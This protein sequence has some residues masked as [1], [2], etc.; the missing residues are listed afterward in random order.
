MSWYEDFDRVVGER[1]PGLEVRREEPMGEHTTFRIGGAARRMALPGDAEEAA[2]LLAL[3][4]EGGWPVLAVG[5]GSNLLV[6]DEGI[7]RLVVL[8][9]RMD[10]VT[11]DG[12]SGAVKTEAGIRLSRLAVAAMEAG[13]GGLA[14]AHGIPGTLG[15]AVMMNAGAYGGEM[16]QVIRRVTAWFPVRGVQTLE[17]EELGFGYR[18]SCF[19]G[20]DGVVLSAELGLQPGCS[21]AEIR[22]EMEALIARRRASQPLELPSA[23]ST[24]K[25]PAGYYAGT[26]IDQCGLKGLRVGGAQVSEKHAGFIVNR[27]GATCADVT[28]LITEVQRRVK[29][30][31]GVTLEPEVRIIR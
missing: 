13:L 1:M 8:T 21:P 14:F 16:A 17:G 26:L 27:G 4:E 3:A 15:G 2:K 10:A 18:R 19:S 24:F 25:R 23:G 7:D 5:N 28:A 20:G 6:A 9:T 31:A 29:E 12:A 22:A 30:A 11:V